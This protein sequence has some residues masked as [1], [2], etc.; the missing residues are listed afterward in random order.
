MPRVESCCIF[1]P[2]AFF[3]TGCVCN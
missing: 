3:F 2:S 1:L